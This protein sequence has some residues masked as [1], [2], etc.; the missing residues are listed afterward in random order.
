MQREVLILREPEIRELLDPDHASLAMEHAFSAYST[1]QAELPRSSIWMSR[2]TT[3]KFTSRPDTVRGGP[4]YAVK[5]VS[6]FPGNPALGFAANDG[7]VVV[8]DARTGAPAAF[9]LDNGYITDLRTG[10]AGAVAAKHLAPAK[11]LQ[12]WR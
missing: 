7:M 1:G 8:F 11:G 2:K 4:H 10:A 12:P 9:L 5:I 6:G 3:A